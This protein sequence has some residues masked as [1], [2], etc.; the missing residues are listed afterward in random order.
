MFRIELD[1]FY[2]LVYCVITEKMLQVVEKLKTG[3]PEIL[4][5]YFD[6]VLQ[7]EL[8]EQ[9]QVVFWIELDELYR[10]VYR[11]VTEK[12][13]EVVEKLKNRFSRDSTKVF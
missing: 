3:F 8:S 12:M 5:R 6:L 11:A 7:S 10:L 13:L 9:D 1:E 4:R 2:R